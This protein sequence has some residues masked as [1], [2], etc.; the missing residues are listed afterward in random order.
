MIIIV[1]LVGKLFYWCYFL[2]GDCQHLW[3]QT[4]R[5]FPLV[6]RNIGIWWRFSRV[7][8]QVFNGFALKELDLYIIDILDCK[9]WC[10][11]RA[12][13]SQITLQRLIVYTL[14]FLP[15]SMF[16]QYRNRFCKK[17][18]LQVHNGCYCACREPADHLWPP[19]HHWKMTFILASKEMC[20]WKKEWWQLCS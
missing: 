12:L 2:V 13:W 1:T 10:P 3:H 6:L 7:W 20:V 18:E 19:G 4:C 8:C 11:V 14:F 5:W 17:V 15:K 9:F 16:A